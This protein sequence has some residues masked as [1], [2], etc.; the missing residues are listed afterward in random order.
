MPVTLPSSEPRRWLHLGMIL[1]TVVVAADQ[2]VKWWILEVVMHPPRVIE[3]TGFFNLV[4]A[5]NRGVSFGLLNGEAAPWLLAAVALAISLALGLWLRQAERILIAVGLGLILGGA[6]GNLIDRIR[7][8]AVTDFLDFHAFGVHF[9]A[10]NVADSAI[11]LGVTVLI[12]DGLFAEG[13]T[14]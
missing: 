12:I 10:F 11:T 9:W 13:D 5:W 8:G 7:F 14:A 4:L 6:L 2:A 1:A 3:I